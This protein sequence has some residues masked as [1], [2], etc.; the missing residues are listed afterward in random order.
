[1]LWV[2][3]DHTAGA[4]PGEPTPSAM[5]ADNDLATGRIIEAI[6][7]SAFWKSSAVFVVE[8]D[9]QNGVD[10]VDGHRNVTLVASP[11]VK[12]GAVV[13]DYYSQLNVTRT[14]EQILGLPR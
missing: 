4:Q 2:M 7:K 14:I 10:H 1:M 5:V 8:D 9:S 6:S 11:Y 3:Q 12:K 13:H